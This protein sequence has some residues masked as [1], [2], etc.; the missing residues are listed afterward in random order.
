MIT[1]CAQLQSE[2]QVLR[3][4]LD[5]EHP[6]ALAGAAAKSTTPAVSA[7]QETTDVARLL[8]DF[9]YSPWIV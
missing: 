5:A 1:C 3:G 9:I 8:R 6:P 4:W 2:F 7:T